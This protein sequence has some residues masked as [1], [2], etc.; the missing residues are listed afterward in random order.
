MK[1][2]LRTVALALSAALLAVSPGIGI[3][4][5]FTVATSN[6]ERADESR[7]LDIPSSE[8]ALDTAN[9]IAARPHY[10]GSD[11]D[12]KLAIYMRD[13]LRDFGFE[14]DLETVTARVD[15]PKKLV[16]E[17]LTDASYVP[18]TTALN[19]TKGVAPIGLDLHE[20]PEATDPATSDPEV[21]IPFNSGAADGDVTAPLVFVNRGLDDDYATLARAHVDVARSI[22]LVRYGGQ[23]RGLLAERAQARG[24]LGVIFYSDPKDDGAARGVVY[25]NGPWRPSTAVQRGSLGENIRIPA[26]PISSANAQIL[27][28]SLSGVPGPTTWGGSLPVAYPLA[29]GPSRVHLVVELSRA[30]KTLWNTIGRI[31]GSR[32]GQSVMLGAHR[33]AWVAGVGDNGAGIMTMLE[34]A[35]GLGYLA[36]SGWR[37]QRTIVVAGWDGEEIGLVGSTAFVKRHAVELNRDCIAYLNADENLTGSTFGAEAAAAIG[38]SI[39]DATRAVEDP[40]ANRAAVY[41]RWS[42]QISAREPNAPRPNLGNPGGGSDHE[43]FL[44]DAGIPVASMGFNG[45]YGVYHSSYD[46]LRYAT[47]YSDP[48]FVFHRTAAQLYGIAAMRLADASVIPYT[49]SNYLPLLRTGYR[50]I[51]TRAQ[52]EHLVIDVTTLHSAIDAFALAASRMDARIAAATQPEFPDRE[53]SAVHD[54]DSLVYGRNGYASVAFPT[55]NAAFASGSAASVNAA[56]QQAAA[57]VARATSS[58]SV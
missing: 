2:F 55:I 56:L 17:L 32:G 27:L 38:P 3:I 6:Q 58:V 57:L 12:H 30:K 49:F 31:R 7:F 25:P 9:V 40:A 44:F 42:K 37:P 45:P 33:D 36:K 19:R 43:S 29:R 23:F 5:G 46:T 4:R 47:T 51:Q 28:A 26:L 15:Y 54:L 14:A 24:A 1:P 16:L 48:G 39:V 50:A 22:V 21:S 18:T 41:E 13:K 35:R 10:A 52:R 8:G 20:L 53:L 11:G 34:M